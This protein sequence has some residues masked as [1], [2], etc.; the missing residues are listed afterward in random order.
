MFWGLL[1]KCD[2]LVIPWELESRASYRLSLSRPHQAMTL[3]ESGLMSGTLSG[4]LRA[5]LPLARSLC[6]TWVCGSGLRNKEVRV[7]EK[8]DA[9]QRFSAL[10]VLQKHLWNFRKYKNLG[11]ASA[12]LNQSLWGS[13]LG[14]WL[15]FSKPQ[16]SFCYAGQAERQWPP[17]GM[18]TA[19]SNSYQLSP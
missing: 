17:W 14:I 8:D 19:I 5:C 16:S 4:Q 13:G 2:D 6:P 15:S 1:N 7:V 9:G 18:G 10:A 12:L 11:L 3:N